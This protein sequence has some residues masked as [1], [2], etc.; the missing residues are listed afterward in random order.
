VYRSG[1]DGRMA[2]IGN[3]IKGL[4][5]L[6]EH[7]VAFDALYD[8]KDQGDLDSPS[9]FVLYDH[10]DYISTHSTLKR[11]YEHL[12]TLTNTLKGKVRPHVDTVISTMA[13][14]MRRG[15]YGQGHEFLTAIQKYD[16]RGR[17]GWSSPTQT[18]GPQEIMLTSNPYRYDKHRRSV[19]TWVP[20]HPV[21]Q[22]YWEIAPE[23]QGYFKLKNTVHG[24]KL[25]AAIDGFRYYTKL[26][27]CIHMGGNIRKP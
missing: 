25:Y 11:M 2:L 12:K 18:A 22:G 8:L 3:F 9:I 27:T 13:A 5:V 24:E 6:G 21:T 26:E 19:Y 10:I 23:S 15:E 1:D 20:G 17:E 16:T 14:N 4:P 7:V